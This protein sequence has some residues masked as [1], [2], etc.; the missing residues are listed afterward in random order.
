MRTGS[1]PK[2]SF[3]VVIRGVSSH[4]CIYTALFLRRNDDKKTVVVWVVWVGVRVRAMYFG[5][6]VRVM[7]VGYGVRVRVY[8]VGV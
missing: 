3:V 2:V 1:N 8:M 7:G 4:R 6:T 5:V